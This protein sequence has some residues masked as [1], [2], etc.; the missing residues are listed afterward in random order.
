MPAL[1]QGALDLRLASTRT[2]AESVEPLY[3]GLLDDRIALGTKVRQDP[4]ISNP[5]ADDATRLTALQ[6]FAGA[7]PHLSGNHRASRHRR[8]FVHPGRTLRASRWRDLG[9][10]GPGRFSRRWSGNRKAG[11]RRFRC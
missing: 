10:L 3:G 5:A 11:T 2:L 6:H 1:R 4:V 7:V 9:A 8:G